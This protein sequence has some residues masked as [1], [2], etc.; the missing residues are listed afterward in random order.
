MNA[1]EVFVKALEAEG[2]KFI[3]G[4]PGARGVLVNEVFAESP[5]GQGGLEIEDVIIA[6]EGVAVT[7]MARLRALVAD[8][9]P[10]DV[11]RFRVVRDGRERDLRVRVGLRPNDNR[12]YATDSSRV[13]PIE[14]LGFS[15]RTFRPGSSEGHRRLYD[16]DARGVVI[17][18]F[19]ENAPTQR[20]L[21]VRELIIECNG[22]RVRTARELREAVE[23]LPTG[24]TV[25]L[26][27]LK[28]T[29]DMR[30]VPLRPGQ[31][32]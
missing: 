22:Q 4:V 29:G 28:P 23:R 17:L 6:V 15:V 12:P 1:S 13:I 18:G 32:P 30:I 21:S 25:E 14:R 3:F 8:L 7:N 31:E 9:T 5:A 19:R 2:V 16:A 27:I 26:K 24:Q 20:Q 11:A 10:G